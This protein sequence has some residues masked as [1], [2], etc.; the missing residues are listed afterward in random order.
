MTTE[1][2]VRRALSLTTERALGHVAMQPTVVIT[3][4]G[5]DRVRAGHPWIYRSD[6]VDVQAAPATPC[7]W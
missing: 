5:E 3:Q 6:L 7:A 1:M 4:R 2:E